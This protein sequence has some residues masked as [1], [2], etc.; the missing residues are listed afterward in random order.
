MATFDLFI[1][2]Q[3]PSLKLQAHVALLQSKHLVHPGF[4]FIGN[5]HVDEIPVLRMRAL[6]STGI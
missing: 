1:M 4:V 5:P 2:L 6:G 3:N